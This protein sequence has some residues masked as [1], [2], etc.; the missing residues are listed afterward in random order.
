MIF[1]YHANKTWARFKSEGFWNSEM[2]HSNTARGVAECSMNFEFILQLASA[3]I[4]R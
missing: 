2:A 1:N 4:F 3:F